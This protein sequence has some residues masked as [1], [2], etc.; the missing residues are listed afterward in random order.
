MDGST[1]DF[2]REDFTIYDSFGNA[3]DEDS[4]PFWYDGEKIQFQSTSEADQ[5]VYEWSSLGIT[6]YINEDPS[7]TTYVPD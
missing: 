1:C 4:T 6:I 7:S 3:L 2:D 5:G